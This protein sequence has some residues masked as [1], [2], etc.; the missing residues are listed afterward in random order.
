[1]F[2]CDITSVA[3]FISCQADQRFLWNKYVLSDLVLQS[4]LHRFALPVMHGFVGMQ[5][6]RIG[7]NPFQLA[8]VSRRSWFRAGTRFF[9]RGIDADGNSA[10]FVETEQI[11]EYNGFL[12]ACVQVGKVLDRVLS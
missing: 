11:L 4:E 5:Q 2:H 3:N 9:M 6:C 1:M 12:C 7:G 10:N 8:L